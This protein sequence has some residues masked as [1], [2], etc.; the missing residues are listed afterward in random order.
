MIK[1]TDIGH[2]LYG[3]L[4]VFAPIHISI[5]M[6]AL[7]VIYELDEEWHLNDEAYRDIMFYMIGIAIG[8]IIWLI[9]HFAS[10]AG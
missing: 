1:Y 4:I 3:V 5:L 10:F 2:I 8:V 6:A 7:F 9:L